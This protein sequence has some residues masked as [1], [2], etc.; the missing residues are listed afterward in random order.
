MSQMVA[1]SP[2]SEKNCP[3]NFTVVMGGCVV[4]IFRGTTEIKRGDSGK[5]T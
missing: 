4:G 2:K 5:Y 1:D 3:L